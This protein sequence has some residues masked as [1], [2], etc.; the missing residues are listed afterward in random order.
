LQH[1]AWKQIDWRT[2]P[3]PATYASYDVNATLLLLINPHD[4]TNFYTKFKNICYLANLAAPTLLM[5]GNLLG[6]IAF[7]VHRFSVLFPP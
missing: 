4:S 2:V 6:R 7:V 3:K 1:K 5:M